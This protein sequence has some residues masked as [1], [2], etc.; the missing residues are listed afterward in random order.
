M[1][2]TRLADNPIIT[3]DMHPEIGGNINGPSMMRV[4][5]WLPDPL[6]RY[7]LYFA[8]HQGKF[9]RLAVADEPAGPWRYVP[10]GTLHL[11]D[12]PFRGHVASPDVHVDHDAR[13]IVM[14]LHGPVTDP[15]NHVA[16]QMTRVA[17][18]ADG[19]QFTCGREVIGRP[20]FRVFRRGDWHYALAMPGQLYRSRD[21]RTNFRRG[22]MLF[23]GQGFDRAMKD[24]A[25]LRQ[26]KIQRHTA[27]LPLGDTLH[28]FYTRAGDAPERILHATI[29]LSADWLD[30]KPT[31]P[32]TLLEPEADWEGSNLPAEPSSFG[33]APQ[34]V[35][36]LRDPAVF[37]EAGRHRLLYSVAGEAG[38]AVAELHPEEPPR[39]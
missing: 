5:D 34:P 11:D 21:G 16:P 15:E 20:Y 30:W 6:G 19:R 36:Q 39:A 38:L 9:I 27:L 37:S 31:E 14:Y 7:Y 28:I 33:W 26:V 22:P 12:T 32:D 25:F 13:E 24:E 1:H 29:D 10:G 8:H 23:G 4:P 17:V 35:C 18:S 2:A 3:P